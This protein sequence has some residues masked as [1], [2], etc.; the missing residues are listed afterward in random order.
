M[1]DGNSYI[2]PSSDVFI[3]EFLSVLY[4]GLVTVLGSL[5]KDGTSEQPDVWKVR[6]RCHFLEKLS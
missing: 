5:S 4:A 1:V 2:F 3:I 6:I